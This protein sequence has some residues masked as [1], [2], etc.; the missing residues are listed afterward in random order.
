MRRPTL[1]VILVLGTLGLI[2]CAPEDETVGGAPRPRSSAVASATAAPNTAS[3]Q[4]GGTIENTEQ[5]VTYTPP[6]TPSP[7]P[8]PKQA[9]PVPEVSVSPDPTPSAF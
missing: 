1:S 5:T 2:A 3:Q 6:P 9:T 8:T 7:A 4:V